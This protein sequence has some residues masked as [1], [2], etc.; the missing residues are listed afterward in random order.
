M[1]HQGRQGIPSFGH[2]QSARS[3]ADLFG[4]TDNERV[5][6]QPVAVF[7]FCAPLVFVV[8]ALAV[9]AGNTFAL[10]AR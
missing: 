9:A 7:T 1:D 2:D 5:A 3:L 4:R 6:V 10:N 8:G